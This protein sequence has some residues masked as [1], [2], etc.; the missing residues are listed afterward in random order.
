MK[1]VSKR[2]ATEQDVINNMAID[3]PGTKELLERL[4]EGRFAWVKVSEQPL[5]A[6]DPGVTD[7]THKVMVE[8]LDGDPENQSADN[9]AR[10]Q[11]EFKEDPNCDL[12]Q[13]GLTVA[14]VQ[15]YIAACS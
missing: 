14:K 1:G 13:A 4:L 6:K 15:D 9:I 5:A 8:P 12:F 11:W 2:I 7:A 3:K 10:F